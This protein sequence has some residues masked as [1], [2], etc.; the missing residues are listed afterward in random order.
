M[1]VTTRIYSR[2]RYNEEEG[3]G[4]P[5]RDPGII[6][7][8]DLC[9]PLDKCASVQLGEVTQSDCE[10]LLQN[11]FDQAVVQVPTSPIGW[12]LVSTKHLGWLVKERR[13]LTLDDSHYL[14]DD[15][16]ELAFDL[17][18]TGL[19]EL[20]GCL[21]TRSAAL[22]YGESKVT[23]FGPA[24]EREEALCREVFGLITLAD[25][26]TQVVRAAA[27]DRLSR[28]EIGL[29]NLVA[30]NHAEPWDWIGKLNEDA[31]V[32]IIG[33]WELS[34]RHN[35]QL[36]PISASTL[37]QLISVLSKSSSILASLGFRS[38]KEFDKSTGKIAAIRNR[39]MHP[40]RPLVL[41]GSE[42]QE[43]YSVLRVL[44][45]LQT[46]VAA[47]IERDQRKTVS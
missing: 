19:D 43:L 20:V 9:I 8:R 32:R 18:F 35:V 21:T 28:L 27:Y 31:Q 22:V 13:A 1:K 29:A 34:K 25:L 41:E 40:V 44:G 46:R 37:V 45:D 30:S 47:V 42:V 5:P 3:L 26:N 16:A 17:W 10:W 7:L 14:P 36:D 12:R 33:S 11:G 15:T 6:D 4:D 38:R 24:D 39:I 23:T 2:D